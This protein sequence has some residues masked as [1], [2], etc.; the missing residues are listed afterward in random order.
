VKGPDGA[1][2][3]FAQLARP[4]A[5]WRAAPFK[6][7]ATL[8]TQA[9][10]L[11]GMREIHKDVP[12]WVASRAARTAA[13]LL[14]VGETLYRKDVEPVWKATLSEDGAVELDFDRPFWGRTGSGVLF[15][16]LARAE[17]EAAA[18]E[19]AGPGRKFKNSG[20]RIEKA[21][22]AFLSETALTA[23]ARSMGLAFGYA[24]SLILRECRGQVPDSLQARFSDFARTM[25][26]GGS[27][28]E[29]ARLLDSMELTALDFTSHDGPSYDDRPGGRLGLGW[30]RHAEAAVRLGLI[31]DDAPAPAIDAI[32]PE[33]D[34][35]L[36]SLG[37]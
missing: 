26:P 16:V 13:D 37:L 11:T 18:A 3:T 34:D 5:Y 14:L 6:A 9:E 29:A 32:A 4:E 36:A 21:D 24:R 30:Q 8:P 2:A 31:A 17:A 7:A 12:D 10:L 27:M 33:D 20:M 35:A 25:A 22:P 23:T 15:P 1:H 28:L 19:L